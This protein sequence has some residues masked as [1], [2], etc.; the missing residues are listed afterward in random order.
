VAVCDVDRRARLPAKERAERH[1]G[2]QKAGG[3]FK[4]CEAYVDYRELCAR[5]DI[6]AVFCATPEHWHGPVS[7][8]AMR[9]GKDVY[10][11]KP[12]TFTI[13]EG[14]VMVETARRY[15]RVFS[16]GS[17][18][19][20]EGYTWYHRMMWSGACG[21]LREVFINLQRGLSTSGEMLLPAEPV[22]EWLDW[23]MWLGPAPWRPYNKDFRSWNECR[24]FGGG[25]V[26]AM[27]PHEIGGGLFA[28]Q[29]HDKPLPVEVMPPVYDGPRERPPRQ[30]TFKYANGVLLHLTG[31]WGYGFGF[32]SLRGTLGEVPDRRGPRIAPPPIS[33]PNYKGRGGIIG[34]FLH[35][36]K[37]R[38][39][40]FRDIEI[41]HRTMVICH[42][43]NIA[44][45]VGRGFKFDPVKE[46]I[47]DDEEANRWVD[48][49]RRAPWVL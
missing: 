9:N 33:I 31:V 42:L 34:D 48:R 37:T 19:V 39:R 8:E 49:P 13:R 4:G 38:E 1:Y 41:A 14:R 29:L 25:S 23:E 32:L 43:A 2:Q 20:W 21:E 28:A 17:Q 10:C 27:G 46:E 47:L 3:T 44:L 36:V 45:W 16:G 6:D 5:P 7:C 40:P 30:L 18:T 12:E 22:P 11:E 15:G 35:C 24:D 26:T